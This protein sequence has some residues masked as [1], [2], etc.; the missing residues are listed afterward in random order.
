M[1]PQE[2]A[3]FIRKA[4]KEQRVIESACPYIPEFFVSIA[5]ASKFAMNQIREA[6]KEVF[7]DFRRG[8]EPIEQLNDEKLRS[9]Y[10]EWIIKDWRGLT[11]EKLRQLIP[12]VE[13][14]EKTEGEKEIPYNHEIAV[15]L[16]ESSIEFENWVIGIATEIRNYSKIAEQKKK[17]IENLE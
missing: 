11:V 2:L 14:A 3:E 1:K 4:G 7:T 9:A 16:L 12:G 8:R 5:Y 13:T 17:E 10:A 6:S 15:A